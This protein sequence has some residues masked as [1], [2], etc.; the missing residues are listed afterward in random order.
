MRNGSELADPIHM[1]QRMRRSGAWSPAC[2]LA[3]V[4]LAA[5]PALGTPPDDAGPAQ[6]DPARLPEGL[7]LYALDNFRWEHWDYF[8]PASPGGDPDYDFFANRLRL[9]LRY[10]R[11]HLALHLAGQYVQL[12]SLP[13]DASGTPGGA[14]G[15]G[16]V[17]YAHARRRDP[18]AVYLKYAIL[19]G[20]DLFERDVD[21]A[22]GR[23]SYSSGLE[24]DSG[25]AKIEAVKK[26]RVSERLIGEFG[27]SHFQRSFDGA[28]LSWRSPVG[29]LSLAGFRPTEGGFEDNVNRTIDKID[30]AAAAYTLPPGL[31]LPGTELQA[32]YYYYDDDRRVRA[33]VDN[34]G[35]APPG[36]QDLGIHSVGGHVVGAWDVGPGQI[37]LLLWGVFQTGHWYEQDHEA[38]GAALEVG[39][40]FLELPG[41]PWLRI[42]SFRGTGDRDPSDDDHDTLFQILPT[43]RRYSLTTANNLM[44]STDSFVS[45]QV[46]PTSKL[47]MRADVHDLRLSERE[48]LWYAGSG[49][50]QASGKIF[51]YAGRSSGDDR[52]LGTAAEL[53]V[54]YRPTSWLGLHAFYGHIWGGDVVDASFAKGDQLDFFFLE[55]TFSWQTGR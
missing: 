4:L 54:R 16:A 40:Q 37:D 47:S 41:K 42:G 11:P 39:Y 32:F 46:Q 55:L 49:A 36:R 50:T 8:D 45:L 18:N 13:D 26:S 53:T 9:G 21:V 51:G 22:V 19:E 17:Y 3:A 43:A 5:S 28:R 30:V 33:R 14:L 35:L 15:T 2:L 24:A 25:I 7:Q 12:L 34:S 48:D 52:H 20:R 44:N 31:V 10:E 38:A 29:Q 6:S 23:L 1:T 27:W